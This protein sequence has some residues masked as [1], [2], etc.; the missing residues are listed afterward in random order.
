MKE[1]D[2]RQKKQ[3]NEGCSSKQLIKGKEQ[4]SKDFDDIGESAV[5]QGGFGILGESEERKLV[6]EVKGISSKEISKSGLIRM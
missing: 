1:E 2:K 6:Q 3:C 5:S 4:Y